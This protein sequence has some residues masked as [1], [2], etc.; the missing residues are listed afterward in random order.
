MN[1]REIRSDHEAHYR[2]LTAHQDGL[3]DTDEQEQL[4]Q[5]RV[6]IAGCGDI[7]SAVAEHLVRSGVEEIK[8]HDLESD[9]DESASG[10]QADHIRTQLLEINPYAQIDQSAGML[11]D[12]AAAELVAGSELVLDVLGF[13]DPDDYESRYRLH[14]GCQAHRVPAISG[15]D[16]GRSAWMFLHD[17]RDCDSEILGGAYD[18]DD[19]DRARSESSASLL[20]NLLSLSKSPPDVLRG[21]ERILLGQ[22][23]SWPRSAPAASLTA[24]IVGQAAIDLLSGRPVKKLV[25]VDLDEAIRPSGSLRR[26][27]RRLAALYSLRRKLRLRR[28]EGRIGVFSPLEDEAFQELAAY[29]EEKL[30]EAGSVIVRQ[31]E[32]AGEFF[33]ITEG[34]VQVEYE[35]HDDDGEITDITVLA[36]LGPGDYFGEMALLTETP[37]VASVVVTERCRVLVLSHGAFEMYLEESDAAAVKVRGEALDRIRQNRPIIGC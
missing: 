2:Q 8:L 22:R 14:C 36:E 19:V 9:R 28:R 26:T 32:I 12:E 1:R 24:G 3:I 7:G 34:S 33:V 30:Y 4:R 11:D 18:L 10:S 15:I 27:G 31:G 6:V 13:E 5:A 20:L 37:R 29:M 21:I 16:V 25:A 35:E 23:D 17:Y